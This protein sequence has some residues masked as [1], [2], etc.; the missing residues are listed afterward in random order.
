MCAW[1]KQRQIIPALTESEQEFLFSQQSA[2][3]SLET[4]QLEESLKNADKY[5]QQVH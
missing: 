4:K 2:L 1:S 5:S 3:S